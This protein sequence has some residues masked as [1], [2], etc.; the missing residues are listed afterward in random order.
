MLYLFDPD[1]IPERTSRRT[2]TQYYFG[3]KFFL[4]F[5]EYQHTNHKQHDDANDD[6]THVIKLEG[7]KRRMRATRWDGRMNKQLDVEKYM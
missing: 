6:E 7:S 3:W 4:F 5:F 1:A 2:S